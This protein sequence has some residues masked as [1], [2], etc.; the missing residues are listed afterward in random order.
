MPVLILQNGPRKGERFS[1]ERSALIGR[2]PLADLQLQDPSVSRR[3]ALISADQGRCFISDLQSGNGTYVN[4][5]RIERPTELYE[6]DE[7]RIGR[8]HLVFHPGASGESRPRTQLVRLTIS[9]QRE[10]ASLSASQ[11]IVIP[12]SVREAAQEKETP[13]V[14]HGLERR[15]RFLARVSREMALNMDVSQRLGKILE[16]LLDLLPQ[17]DRAFVVGVDEPSGGFVPLAGRSRGESREQVPVSRTLLEQVVQ[18]RQAFLSASVRE[19]VAFS[20][21]RSVQALGLYSVA[22]VPLEV[23]GRLLGVLQIDNSQR[24]RPFGNADLEVLV[25]VASSIALAVAHAALQREL[26]ERELWEHDL[27]LARKIQLEFVPKQVVPPAGYQVAVEYSPALAVGGDLYDVLEL[28]GNRWLFAIGDV[29]GKGVSGA[30]MMARLVAEL[31]ATAVRTLHPV[32]LLQELN[33]FL[34]TTAAAGVFVTLLVGVL[35]PVSGRIEIASAGHPKPI[36]RRADG[37]CGELAIKPGVALGLQE[38]LAVEAFSLE[39][40][41]GDLLVLFSDGLSEAA[42]Q[43]GQRF[44]STGIVSAVKA[45]RDPEDGLA[46]L[47]LRAREFVAQRQFEDDLTVLVLGRNRVDGTKMQPLAQ[48]PARKETALGFD[49]S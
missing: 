32:P 4:G 7:V 48:A 1:F 40:R 27:Q 6:G 18:T 34:A 41:P 38:T 22:S 2:G 10:R 15:L 14:V 16:A 39:L 47:L 24:N 19:E 44:G 29:S 11:S 28:P 37:R 35:D 21:A 8:L 13:D 12:N 23:E 31:R 46:R 20:A 17:A 43:E 30:L 45:G 36:L 3:H 42:N 33:R 26:V 49:S 9:E 25:A 5:V